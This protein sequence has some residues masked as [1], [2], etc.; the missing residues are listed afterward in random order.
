M[1]VAFFWS[2]V[3]KTAS[4]P[5]LRS[6]A[7]PSGPAIFSEDVAGS[8]VCATIFDGLEVG[9]VRIARLQA[10]ALHLVGDPFGGSFASE[11][12]GAA[13]FVLVVGQ[14]LD[15]RGDVGAEDVG[16]GGED[17][18]DRAGGG[19]RLDRLGRFT[20]AATGGQR[21]RHKSCRRQR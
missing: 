4:G 17:G 10:D 21:D 3:R 11:R 5:S 13:A 12:A 16:R 9:A 2:L 15:A 19:R 6:H 8:T 14:F 7:L 18:A 1:T 20:A